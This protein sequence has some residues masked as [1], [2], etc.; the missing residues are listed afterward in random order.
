MTTVDSE[1]PKSK[2]KPTGADTQY[3]HVPFN[4]SIPRPHWYN[5]S[6]IKL[7]ASFFVFCYNSKFSNF[8]SFVDNHQKKFIQAFRQVFIEVSC[9]PWHFLVFYKSYT[10]YIFSLSCSW[11]ADSGRPCASWFSHKYKT[12]IHP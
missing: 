7:C 5:N 11:P 1:V 4:H 6:C 9:Q 10:A 3:T 12:H 8:H 2:K